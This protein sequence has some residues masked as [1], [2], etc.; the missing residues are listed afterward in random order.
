[1]HG[2][3]KYNNVVVKSYTTSPEFHTNNIL[4]CKVL[5]FFT[6]LGTVKPKYSSSQKKSVYLDVIKNFNALITFEKNFHFTMLHLTIQK[7]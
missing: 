7:T 3:Y 5:V 2:E 6:S 1:M 4:Y